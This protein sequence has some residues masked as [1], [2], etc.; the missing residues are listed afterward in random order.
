VLPH[1]P[2]ALLSLTRTAWFAATTPIKALKALTKLCQGRCEGRRC[3][4]SIERLPEVH[5]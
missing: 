1:W 5:T 2:L 3:C 4:C